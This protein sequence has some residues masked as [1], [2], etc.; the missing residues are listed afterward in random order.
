M[1]IP[2]VSY[3][4]KIA[5]ADSVEEQVRK[6]LRHVG[7]FLGAAGHYL[8]TQMTAQILSLV[9]ASTMHG[10][11]RLVN[12]REAMAESPYEQSQGFMQG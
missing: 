3:V 2:S 8:A 12:I 5:C 4:H 6:R 10:I 7:V 9:F 11:A 1:R